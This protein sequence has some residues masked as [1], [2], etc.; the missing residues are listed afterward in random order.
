MKRAFFILVAILSLVLMSSTKI[1]PSYLNNQEHLYF[2]D[3]P[4]TGNGKDFNDSLLSKGY[5]QY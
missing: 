4:L 2:Y 1:T 3:L 5:T